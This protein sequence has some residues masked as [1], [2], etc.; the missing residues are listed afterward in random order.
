MNH[1]GSLDQE[2]ESNDICELS[3]AYPY[4]STSFE[5]GSSAVSPV[6]HLAMKTAII[7]K[8]SYQEAP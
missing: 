2:L 5:K 6:L 8:Y 1:F 7:D 3:C 4:N